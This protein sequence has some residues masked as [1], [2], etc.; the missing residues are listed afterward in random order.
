MVA[1][2]NCIN[3]TSASVTF[4]KS[5]IGLSLVDNK[6]LLGSRWPRW[7][8]LRISRGFGKHAC[9][10]PDFGYNPGWGGGSIMRLEVEGLLSGAPLT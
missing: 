6:S 1:S 10:N 3:D 5:F 2:E 4:H 9:V 7:E 8:Q